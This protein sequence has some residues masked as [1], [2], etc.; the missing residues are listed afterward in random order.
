[1]A[2]ASPDR[3]PS[4][5]SSCGADCL[6]EWSSLLSTSAMACSMAPSP[7]TPASLFRTRC[8]QGRASQG[9]VVASV[10]LSARVNFTLQKQQ[11]VDYTRTTQAVQDT[12]CRRQCGARTMQSRRGWS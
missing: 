2:P 8:S 12:R 6:R 5:D 11:F 10:S 3:L 9:G 4:L 7:S 1:M